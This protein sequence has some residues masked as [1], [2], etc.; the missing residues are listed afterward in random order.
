M[1]FRLAIA[2]LLKEPFRTLVARPRSSLPRPC[3]GR[4]VSASSQVHN[5]ATSSATASSAFR[6]RQSCTSYTGEGE[7]FPTGVSVSVAGNDTARWE[8]L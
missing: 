2:R 1:V 8:M 6:Q 5:F 4:V 3:C 7:G